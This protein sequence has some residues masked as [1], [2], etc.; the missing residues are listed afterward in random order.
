M[1]PL[2]LLPQQ[3][4]TH[5]QD[6]T[7][8]STRQ[9]LE[10]LRLVKAQ[11]QASHLSW[12]QGPSNQ[13]CAGG[14]CLL[15]RTITL[16][17]LSKFIFPC[18]SSCLLLCWSHEDW[19][20]I[21]EE[22]IAWAWRE[23]NLDPTIHNHQ[24]SWLPPKLERPSRWSELKKNCCETSFL[25]GSARHL[26]DHQP[27]HS[28]VKLVLLGTIVCVSCRMIPKQRSICFPSI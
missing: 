9:H 8:L 27:H 23:R 18:F 26:E 22:G 1:K 17:C 19:P 10:V 4:Q 21:S 14:P 7:R 28:N 15:F 13:T 3:N 11:P 2:T 12:H 16:P 20:Q 25:K 5:T 6:I 24:W